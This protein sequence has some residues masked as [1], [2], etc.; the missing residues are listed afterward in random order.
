MRKPVKI[1]TRGAW[2]QVWMDTGMDDLK[3]THG[4]PVSNTTND[5]TTNKRYDERRVRWMMRARQSGWTT[6]TQ[7][8]SN[9][10]S[11]VIGMFLNI[12]ILYSITILL[13]R[14]RQTGATKKEGRTVWQV[15]P[16]R[17]RHI[18]WARVCLFLLFTCD[19]DNFFLYVIIFKIII[20]I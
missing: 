6:K 11:W 13:F 19:N 18:V 12:F 20:H 1:H 15:E 3:Y 7:D 8:T 5:K 16:K 9:D 4:L 14:V 10:V 17:P 2:V